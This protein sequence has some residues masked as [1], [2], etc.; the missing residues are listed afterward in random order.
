MALVSCP[1][2]QKEVSD[3]APACI[4]CGRPMKPGQVD[5]VNPSPEGI[6]LDERNKRLAA[7]VERKCLEGYLITFTDP[8]QATAVLHR[9]GKDTSWSKWGVASLFMDRRE[10]NIRIS[11]D[12]TGR[13]V[14]DQG[15]NRVGG[16]CTACGYVNS[17]SR[18]SCKSCRQPLL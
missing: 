8:S 15:S 13:V 1:D 3:Q 11:V 17:S 4:H 18:K 10:Q 14:D 12:A 16:A 7:V 9:P 6:S 5:E 2:C